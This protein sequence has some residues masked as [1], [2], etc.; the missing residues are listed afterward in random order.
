[1]KQIKLIIALL[2]FAAVVSSCRKNHFDYQDIYAYVAPPAKPIS[3]SAPLCGSV[4]GTM[5]TGKTYTVAAD[6]QV[7]AGDSLVIQPGVRINFTNSAGIIVK[8][9]FFSLGTKD[10]PIYLTV[11]GQTKA[12]APKANYKASN[13]SA[14]LGKWKGVLGDVTC[15]YMIFKWTHLEYCGAPLGAGKADCSGSPSAAYVVLGLTAADNSY[16][17]YFSNP[18]GYFVFEDSWIY[19][20]IDDAIRIGGAGGKFAIL[21]STFEKCGKSGG[22]VLNIKAGGVGDMAYNFFMGCATN[23]LK[24]ANSGSG[25]GIDQCEAN[26]YNNTLV[27]CGY[28]Q[29]KTGRGGSI[30]FENLA[31]GRAFNNLIVNCKFG[32][33][34]SSNVPDTGY[35][36]NGNYG[37]NY[38]YA[39]SL[40]VANQIF[41]YTPGAVTKPTETD[42]P[43]PS[44]YLPANYVYTPNVAYNGQAAVQVGDPQFFTYNLPVTGGFTLPDM[45]AVGNFKFTLKPT[46]PCISKGYTGFTPLQKV[47]VDSKY[48]VTEYTLP[49]RDI[50]CFQYIGTGNQHY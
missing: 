9:N 28:R 17:A 30:N 42:F 7:N 48:G 13:D 11:A 38:Y 32:L 16:A 39:D 27:N 19:G 5:I 43:K 6:I 20:T 29:T 41:P 12:D 31:R 14:F 24:A 15:K 10:Q 3:D 36:Y 21:R 2:A 37:Y 18:N 22:D 8:G 45:N 1:M 25:P 23:A 47:P 26:I 44:S 4:N 49:G 33:R 46:S 40:S 35:L 34:L 50:G